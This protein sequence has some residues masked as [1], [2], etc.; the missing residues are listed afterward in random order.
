MGE[1]QDAAGWWAKAQEALEAGEG[2]EILDC[3]QKVLE[4][5]ANHDEA[6]KLV[7]GLPQSD[8]DE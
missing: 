5:D 4:H 8:E 1:P 2:N 3:T 7:P 6:K